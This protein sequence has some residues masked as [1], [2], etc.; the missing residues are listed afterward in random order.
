MFRS[1]IRM[2]KMCVLCDGGM[3]VCARWA[4]LGVS[5]AADLLGISCTTVSGVYTK[6]MF[7]NCG[8]SAV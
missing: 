8:W 6:K 3:V 7:K 5:E 2:G 1:N 4:A